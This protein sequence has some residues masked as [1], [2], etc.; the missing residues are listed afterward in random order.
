MKKHL[1]VWCRKFLLT[2]LLR[3][4]TVT[5]LIYACKMWFLLTCLLRGMTK[6]TFRTSE[7]SKFLLTCL[8]RGMTFLPHHHWIH[9]SVSTHMPLT[10]HDP[11]AGSD[12]CQSPLFLLTC[13]LRGMTIPPVLSCIYH[14][15]STHMPL[16]RHDTSTFESSRNRNVSTHM[17]LTRHD[18][19][20]TALNAYGLGFYSHASYEAWQNYGDALKKA[21][22]VSTHMPLTRHDKLCGRHYRIGAFLLTCLLRGMTLL[23]LRRRTCMVCFYSHA[24]YEAWPLIPSRIYRILCFY[25]HASYEAWLIGAAVTVCF[26]LFLLTCLLRGMTGLPDT[27]W[28]MT[29]SFYSHASYEAWRGSFAFMSSSVQFLLTCLLRG[30]TFKKSH[31][32]KF[33]EFLL[34]CLLRG[35]TKYG[36][37]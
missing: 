31:Y 32:G 5:T 10:R 11:G 36:Y 21:E 6:Y 33:I 13:L 37:H 14:H 9:F 17:P 25:S 28:T 4:M 7:W 34:T 22:Q 3:G 19:L 1:A 29:I 24:S 12:A 27:H 35:M 18:I 20:T 8:L 2:C 23:L 26:I 16:T 15:V 30:M